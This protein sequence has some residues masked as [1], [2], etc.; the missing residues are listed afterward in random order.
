MVGKH[1]DKT[2]KRITFYGYAEKCNCTYCS[3]L[4]K[5]ME[6]D[7]KLHI[8]SFKIE[9]DNHVSVPQLGNEQK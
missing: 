3:S 2:M 7:E 6:H 5:I 1:S 8:N 4:R 9:D